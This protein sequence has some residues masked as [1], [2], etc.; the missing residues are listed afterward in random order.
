NNG[1]L[2]PGTSFIDPFGGGTSYNFDG[3]V[4][5]PMPG[6][7][8]KYYIF[9][10]A[11][12]L[13]QISNT[14]FFENTWTGKLYAT[15]VDME[16][17]NGLGGVD[18]NYHGVEVGNMMAGNLHAVVGENC[19]YWLIGFGSNGVYKAFNITEEGLNP[20]PVVSTLTPPL[21]SFV[22][23]LNVSPDRRKI[24]MACDNEVQ[25]AD[26][27]PATGLVSNDQLIGTQLTRYLAFSPNS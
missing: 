20:E 22:A 2:A 19:D 10:T 11:M 24:A 12:L 3:V 27:D 25:V 1:N 26:F 23:E 16:L 17:G 14:I 13:V 6:S 21:S 7:S 18:V 8:H 9:S 5:V 15:I 4:I